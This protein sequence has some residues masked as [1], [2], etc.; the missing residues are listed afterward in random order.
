MLLLHSKRVINAIKPEL[1]CTFTIKPN[2]Y[3]AI[4]I[5]GTPIKQIANITGLGY[6]FINGSMKAKL[7]SLL[8]RY[9]LKSVNHIF[10][11]NSD[12]YSFL[13]Q[14]NIITKERSVMIFPVRVLI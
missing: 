14:S 3:T 6:A 10:F 1:I 8:Y 9:V 11:Q 2:L 4:V 13:L 12:D 7:F 5:K